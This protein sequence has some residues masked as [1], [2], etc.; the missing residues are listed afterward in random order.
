MSTQLATPEDFEFFDFLAPNRWPDRTP[1]EISLYRQLVAHGELQ[2]ETVLENALVVVSQG[3]YTRIAEDHADCSDGSDAKKSCSNFRNN[4]VRLKKWMNTFAITNL[5][6]KTGLIRALCFS[7]V[8]AK[9]HFYAIPYKAYRGMDR[10]EITLDTSTGYC[11]PK[12]IPRG[13]WCVFEVESFETLARV[14]HE[15]QARIRF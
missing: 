11:E 6:N 7:K 3:Q 15:Q 1:S 9:F 12:G 10:V 13:K 8:T 4:N 2:I 14:T 5:K